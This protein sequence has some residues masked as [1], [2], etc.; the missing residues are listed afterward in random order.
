MSIWAELKR[1][2]VVRVAGGYALMGWLTLQ[3][4]SV[5]ILTARIA[6]LDSPHGRTCSS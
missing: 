4:T 1:R 2:K 6:W 5:L 3:L